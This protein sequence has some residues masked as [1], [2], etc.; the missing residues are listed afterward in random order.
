[1]TQTTTT[2]T[3]TTQTT[4]ETGHDPYAGK[5]ASAIAADM[6]RDVV[7]LRWLMTVWAIR[8]EIEAARQRDAE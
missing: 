4:L 8:L 1:M 5:P 3:P 6:I 2:Q 7:E